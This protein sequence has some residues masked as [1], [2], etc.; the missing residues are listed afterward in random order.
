MYGWILKIF[1]QGLRD[2]Q[3]V[4]ETYVMPQAKTVC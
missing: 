2:V 3:G 1:I 4:L